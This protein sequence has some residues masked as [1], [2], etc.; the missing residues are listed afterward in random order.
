MSGFFWPKM[1]SSGC[2]MLAAERGHASDEVRLSFYPM[3]VSASCAADFNNMLD[4]ES[5]PRCNVEY[6]H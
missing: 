2:L 4:D 6:E 3:A 1:L 5:E